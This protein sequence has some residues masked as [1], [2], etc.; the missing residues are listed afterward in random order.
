[1]SGG[2]GYVLS[3]GALNKFIF[4]ALPNTTACTNA[5]TAEDVNVAICLHSVGVE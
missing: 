4:E 1:M 2:A 5:T 3:R